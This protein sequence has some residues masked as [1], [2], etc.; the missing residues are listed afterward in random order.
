M[1]PSRDPRARRLTAAFVLAAS[2]AALAAPTAHA[3]NSNASKP[4]T[5]TLSFEDSVSRKPSDLRPDRASFERSGGLGLTGQERPAA[6]LVRAGSI[7]DLESGDDRDA[8]G[9]VSRPELLPG[10]ILQVVD[11]RTG[12]LYAEAMFDGRPSLDANACTGA[13]SATGLRSPNADVT[14]VGE[15]ANVNNPWKYESDPSMSTTGLIPNA[16]PGVFEVRFK[17]PLIAGHLVWAETTLVQSPSV[18]VTSYSERFVTA[19]PPPPIP[20]D[21]LPP[22]GTAAPAAVAK[23]LKKLAKSGLTYRV[24]SGEAATVNA[25]L[26]LE[27]TR[28]KGKKKAPKVTSLIVGKTTVTVPAG[29]AI[30]VNVKIDPTMKGKVISAAK[31]KGSRLLLSTTL[32]DAAGNVSTLPTTTVKFPKK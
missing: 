9:G 10:D 29:G 3:T 18:T 30:D 27:T 5:W 24:S 32:T 23:S 26:T 20:P 14:G 19:C 8:Y 13:I 6:R 15:Y 21:T 12:G 31:Q 7:I 16:G 1:F 22:A 4:V 28:K 25:V 11:T 2:T 17:R